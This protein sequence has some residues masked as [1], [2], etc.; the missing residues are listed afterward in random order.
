MERGESQRP[1]LDAYEDKY[2]LNKNI[3]LNKS[4]ELMPIYADKAPEIAK[5]SSIK[6]DN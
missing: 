1:L 6:A 4:K 3:K 2:A 5:N